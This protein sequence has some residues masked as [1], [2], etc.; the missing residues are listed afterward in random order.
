MIIDFHTHTFP[1]AIAERAVSKLASQAD[2]K[3]FALGTYN[4]LRETSVEAGIDCSVVLPVA[5]NPK[6]C[7]TINRVAAE[8]NELF[9]DEGVMSFGGIH[10][11]NEN[12]KEILNN[13]K[14]NGIKGIKLH[15]VYQATFIDD[16]KNMHIIDYASELGMI[17]IIHAGFDIGFPGSEEA[18]VPHIKNMMDTVKPEKLVLA[19]LGGWYNWDEVE[20]IIAGT[21]VWLDTAYTLRPCVGMDGRLRKNSE[22]FYISNDQFLRIVRK[23]GADKVLFG[24]DSPWG[25]RK[26]EVKA[27]RESG[28]TREEQ[29]MILGGNATR[30]LGL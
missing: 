10:P 13:L 17:T 2:I 25:S 16:I 20:E 12:Y 29:D 26:E 1:D 4:N 9:W 7:E 8:T 14:A 24:T 22:G 30:L 3:N 11:D 19:H 27:I 28:L 18:T 5:T 21:N 6:Q 15:P 23:H